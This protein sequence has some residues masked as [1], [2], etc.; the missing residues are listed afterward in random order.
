MCQLCQV[1]L[2]CP[3]NFSSIC[4]SLLFALSAS[5]RSECF[6]VGIF[7]SYVFIFVRRTLLN[8]ENVICKAFFHQA[9][10]KS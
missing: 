2:L 8:A 10:T 1:F 6:V 4:Y 3:V 5:L 9:Y 7:L